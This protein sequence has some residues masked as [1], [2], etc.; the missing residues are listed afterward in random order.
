MHAI[1]GGLGG[2]LEG[3]LEEEVSRLRSAEDEQLTRE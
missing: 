1:A 3:F 2:I